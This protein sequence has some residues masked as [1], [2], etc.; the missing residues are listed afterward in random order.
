MACCIT[1]RALQDTFERFRDWGFWH[2]AFRVSRRVFRVF[3][4]LRV[5]RVFRVANKVDIQ[6]SV[7]V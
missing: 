4:V 7:R 3:R 1:G 6:G 5:F 2:R